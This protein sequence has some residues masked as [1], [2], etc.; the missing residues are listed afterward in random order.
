MA[1]ASDQSLLEAVLDSW[2][3]NNTILVGLLRAVAAA[4]RPTEAGKLEVGLPAAGRLAVRAMEGGPSVAELLTHIHYVRLVFV[5]E[6]A[7]E[8][9]GKLPEEEWVGEQ[10]PG[11]IAQML[12]ESAKAVRE[13]VKSRVEAGRDMD[14]H[15]DHPILLLQHM[16]WHEG[17]HHGQIKLALKLAGRPI[18]DKEVGPITWGVWMRKK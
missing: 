14:L 17:Y 6:D 7:P 1:N 2:D 8:F 9:A 10:D 15:Y 5:L 16:I 11:R 18:S 12:N 13:A 4:E 3:R